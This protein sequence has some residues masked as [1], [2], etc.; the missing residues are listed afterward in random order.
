MRFEQ[1]EYELDERGRIVDSSVVGEVVIPCDDVVL[2]IGQENA[3]TWIERDIGL[4]FDEWGMPVVDERTFQSTLPGVFFGGDAAFGPKNIIWAVE[5]GH[6]AAI[7]IHRYCEGLPVEERLPRGVTLTTAKMGIHEWGYSNDYDP[8]GRRIMPHVDLKERFKKLDIEVE[9][10]FPAE[11]A[12]VEV[13]RCLNCDL[14]TVFTA[15]LCIECDACIDICPVDC[16]TI[17][18][19][20]E[21]EEVAA[22]LRTPRLEPDQPLY[23]SAALEQTGRVMVKDENLCVHCGLCAE[24]C[25]TGAWDMQKST[26]EIP[27]AAD[28][29]GSSKNKWRQQRAAS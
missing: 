25:P 7:S 14:Q 28:E 29:G 9:I 3:F 19:N 10:G 13:E 6:Q 23:V 22:R 4:E 1:L 21:P 17:T 16:L 5:H 27:Y 26:I 11:Q 18:A 24:R 20:G 2:A 12:A 8:A 15:R